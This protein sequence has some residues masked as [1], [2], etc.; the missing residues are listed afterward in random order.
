MR[1]ALKLSPARLLGATFLLALAACDKAAT[2]STAATGTADTAAAAPAAGN[3]VAV[4]AATPEGGFRIGNPDAK[5]KLVEFASLTCPHCAEFEAEAMGTIRSKYVAS[6]NVSYEFRN[7]VLNGPD[8]AASLLAR[9]QGPDQFF[10]L[11]TSF[12]Q[13]QANWTKPFMSLTPAEQTRISALPQDQQIAAMATAGQLDAYVRARGIPRAKFDQCLT[14][15]AQLNR[16]EALRKEATDTYKLTGTPGFIINGQTQ[17][18]VF[19]WADLEPKLQA[20][21]R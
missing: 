13:D 8:F 3:W 1:S 5:V 11:L 12:F 10:A 4:T 20:A 19:T 16:I 21:L 7:F 14:D 17:E 2:T 18:G 6:G 15:K 9:C